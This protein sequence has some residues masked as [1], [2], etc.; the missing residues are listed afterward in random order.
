MKGVGIIPA[1]ICMLQSVLGLTMVTQQCIG[2]HYAVCL[3]SPVVLT[4]RGAEGMACGFEQ[5]KEG[6]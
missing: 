5:N 3:D 6:T 2:I 4:G 1:H